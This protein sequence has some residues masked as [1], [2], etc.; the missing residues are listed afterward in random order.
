MLIA[1]ILGLAGCTQAPKQASLLQQ[2]LPLDL[3]LEQRMTHDQKQAHKYALIVC[4]SNEERFAS[5]VAMAYAGL[6]TMH[7]LPEH[8][9]ILDAERTQT[10]YP[11]DGFAS[12]EQVRTAMK[13]LAQIVSPQDTVVLCLLDHGALD[14]AMERKQSLVLTNGQMNVSEFSKLLANIHPKYG[15]LLTDFCYAGAFVEKLP[16]TFNGIS[17]TIDSEECVPEHANSF[18]WYF[19]LGAATQEADTNHDG[20]HTVGELFQYACKKHTWAANGFTVP[21]ATG[22]PNMQDISLEDPILD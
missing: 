18:A 1:G 13:H 2:N 12:L 21:L 9:M 14:Y 5:H 17:S 16:N 3:P 4:G 6:Q 7:F 20:R 10:T 11:R 22:I 8:I 19:F 15:L